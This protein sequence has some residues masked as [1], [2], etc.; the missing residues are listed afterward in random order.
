MSADKTITYS[1]RLTETWKKRLERSAEHQ[2]ISVNQ[3]ITDI[4]AQHYKT[5]GFHDASSIELK[6]GRAL[7]LRVKP[8]EQHAPGMP[9][10]W[11]FLDDP[12]RDC[13]VAAYQIGASN[14]LIRQF[15]IAPNDEYE[16]VAEL[17]AALLHHHNEHGANITRL[18]WQQLPTKPDLRILDT[19]DVKKLDGTYIISQV[20]FHQALAQPNK[21]QDRHLKSIINPILT[22]TMA[23]TLQHEAQRVYDRHIDSLTDQQA[24][25]QLTNERDEVLSLIGNLVPEGLAKLGFRDPHLND[26]EVHIFSERWKAGHPA[27][28][29]NRFISGI[30]TENADRAIANFVYG[31]ASFFLDSGQPY[32]CRWIEKNKEMDRQLVAP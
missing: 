13:E 22:K 31:L 30:G 29:N 1:L 19:N 18:E 32:I 26:K 14:Q 9:T 27:L 4:I 10:C 21:W 23:L 16:V 2:G 28:E 7:K 5:A 11:F 15:G 25:V 3:L 17:G 20:D 12:S 6:N 24:A 8:V